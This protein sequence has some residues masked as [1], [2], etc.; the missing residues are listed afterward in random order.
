MGFRAHSDVLSDAGTSL[1]PEPHSGLTVYHVVKSYILLPNKT[2]WALVYTVDSIL[3]L[4]V[5]PS[6]GLLVVVGPLL[7]EHY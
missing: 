2:E 7:L 3:Y 1:K 4:P 6:G 5:A